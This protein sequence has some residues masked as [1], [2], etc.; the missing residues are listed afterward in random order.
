MSRYSELLKG[1]DSLV[2]R[3][4]E[5]NNEILK[6]SFIEYFGEQRRTLINALFEEIVY[7][8][9]VNWDTINLVCRKADGRDKFKPYFEFY[10]ARES[11]FLSFM[12]GQVFPDNFVG[13]TDESVFFNI[14]IYTY[15]LAR[16]KQVDPYSYLKSDLFGTKRMIC[17][18]LFLT[19]EEALIHEINHALTSAWM[20]K[21][22][23]DDRVLLF[24]KTGLT[25]YDD[26]E[27]EDEILE[28]L[29]TDKSSLKIYEIFKRRGGDLTSF[30]MGGIYES[31]YAY[32]HY[33][34]EEFFDTFEDILK[35]ARIDENKNALIK[36]VGKESYYLLCQLI[37][38]YYALECE[39]DEKVKTGNLA[40]ILSVVDYMKEYA[41]IQE[42]L[43]DEDLKEY[44]KY[45]EGIGKKVIIL[46]KARS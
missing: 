23:E 16:L 27:T 17:F 1:Y 9:Y 21:K 34:V 38:N 22:V 33:L 24:E 42:K 35:D 30:L 13:T 39:P 40:R 11:M 20:L 46:N 28:E 14:N 25:I 29:I 2:K 10:E 18:N 43:T 45:L 37:N 44:Y 26:E 19:S 12:Q 31:V 6:E 8:Y 15:V 3:E 36:R 5:K 41:R 32:N 7:V 4:L